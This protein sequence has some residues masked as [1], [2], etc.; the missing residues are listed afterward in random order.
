MSALIVL[1]ESFWVICPC[2][3]PAFKPK[4]CSTTT[5]IQ[6]KDGQMKQ[7]AEKAFRSRQETSPENAD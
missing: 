5:I 2:S 1:P 6:E 4:F 3:V 7:D